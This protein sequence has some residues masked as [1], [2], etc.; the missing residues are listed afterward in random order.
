MILKTITRNTGG[1][2]GGV[3]N[4]LFW[5][6]GFCNC[7]LNYWLIFLKFITL[8]FLIEHNIYLQTCRYIELGVP[9]IL[10]IN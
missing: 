1:K 4:I 7:N 6:F 3:T 2:K 5:F 8:P 10:C 9:D